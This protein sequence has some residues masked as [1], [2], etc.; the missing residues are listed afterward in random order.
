MAAPSFGLPAVETCPALKRCLKVQRTARKSDSEAMSICAQCYAQK[1]RYRW[2][3]IKAN[4]QWRL[5]WWKSTSARDRAVVLA[6]EVKK[7]GSPAYFRCYDSGD[8]DCT[9]AA[10][11]WLYMADMLPSTR[12]W[13]PTKTWILPEFLPVLRRLN[14]HPRIV[15]RPSSIL[16]GDRAP[17]VEG[18]AAGS[19]APRSNKALGLTADRVCPGQ[20]G[21]CRLCWDAPELSVEYHRK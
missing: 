20:C 1:S 5:G 21:E 3:N 15:V 8:L 7:E 19:S 2:R 13:L 11:T 6:N 12:L 16:F 4:L 9:E 14:E 10:E 17:V 18:L